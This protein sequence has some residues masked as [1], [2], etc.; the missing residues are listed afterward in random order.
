MRLVGSGAPR[1]RRVLGVAG[2]GLAVTVLMAAPASAEASGERRPEI[3]NRASC[4]A[5]G[6]DFA[7]RGRH[8]TCTVVTTEV[9]EGPVVSASQGQFSTSFPGGSYKASLVGESQRRTTV[10]TTLVRTQVASRPVT[11]TSAQR[12]VSSVVVPTS[13]VHRE[14][15]SQSGFTDRT[16]GEYVPGFHRVTDQPTSFLVCESRG[17]F[18]A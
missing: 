9:V 8:R 3:I 10:Q 16:T 4:A 13:C 1:G 17:L 6:G 15:I 12:E 5:A 2:A 14:E 11:E 18:V 7:A